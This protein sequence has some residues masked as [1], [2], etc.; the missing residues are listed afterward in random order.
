MPKKEVSV[1]DVVQ[2]VYKALDPL[3]PDER[4]RVLASVRT[5]L[6]LPPSVSVP[7]A[8]SAALPPQTGTPQTA[9]ARPKSVVELMQEKRPRTNPEK[10]ALFAYYREKYE[11]QSRFAR[12][13]LLG[14]FSKS[15]ESPPANFDRDFASAVK[16]GWIHEDGAESYLTSKGLEAVESG[17]EQTR[18]SSAPPR[19]RS[20]HRGGRSKPPKHKKRR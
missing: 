1:V 19:R 8:P 11:R 2:Q 3:N 13:D 16:Q 7:G 10:I 4:E 18:E 20:T 12:G 6:G 9:A 17:F 14:Y 15:R 5:L